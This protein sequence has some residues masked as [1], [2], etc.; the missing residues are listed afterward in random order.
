MEPALAEPDLVAGPGAG[1]E[2]RLHL[3]YGEGEDLVGGGEGV[4]DPVPVVDV[5]VHVEDPAEPG[6]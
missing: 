4:L 6:L 2:A 1:E 5:Q 3:V